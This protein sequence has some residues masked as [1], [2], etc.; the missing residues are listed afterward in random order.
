MGS[1]G[2]VGG[3]GREVG[4]G[5][6]VGRW[7][8]EG[9]HGGGAR[10]RGTEAGHGGGAR[11]WGTAVGH[12]GGVGVGSVCVCCSTLSVPPCAAENAHTDFASATSAT[13]RPAKGGCWSL[14]CWSL[15]SSRCSLRASALIAPSASQSKTKRRTALRSAGSPVVRS[16]TERWARLRGGG[17]AW[18]LVATIVAIA[19]AASPE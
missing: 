6:G 2:G 18:S 9:G 1:G 13:E 17:V 4:H 7:G 16:A 8:T 10:R 14:A 19:A 5:G 3:W 12:G 15:R 11:K